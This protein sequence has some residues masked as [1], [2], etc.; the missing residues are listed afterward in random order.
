VNPLSN[1]L[2]V[3]RQSLLFGGLESISHN[4]NRKNFNLKLFE[5]GKI[6]HYNKNAASSKSLAVYSEK[7]QLALFV[8]GSANPENWNTGKE[9]PV[10]FYYLKAYINNIFQRSGIDIPSFSMKEISNDIFAEGLEYIT[11]KAAIASF[12]SI[13]KTLLKK[14][15]IKQDVFYAVLDWAKI[16]ELSGKNNIIFKDI[17]KFPEVRRDLALLLDK[18]IKFSE[19]E[20]LAYKT[21]PKFLKRV[22]L[23]DI[24]SGKGIEENKKSYAVSFALI[25]EEKTLTDQEI[26]RIM[27][28]FIKAYK[29]KLDVTIR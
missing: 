23:F 15:D 2:A 6:Y 4:H 24:Y 5:I 11:G 13:T 27:N 19:I 3:M 14:F 25:D 17:P 18:K 9:N 12:G 26:E 16:V 29:E 22:N 1:E 20:E 21:E 10:S 7:E 8:T 28:K